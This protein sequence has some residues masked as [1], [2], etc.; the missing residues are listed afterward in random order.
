MN[1]N[2]TAFGSFGIVITMIGWLF[3]MLTMSLVCAVFSPVWANWRQ[4][5]RRYRRGGGVAEQQ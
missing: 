4:T 1:A 2:G 3:I 5:E